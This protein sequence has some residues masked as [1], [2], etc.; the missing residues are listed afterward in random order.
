ML[1]LQS[2]LNAIESEALTLRTVYC[3]LYT[4]YSIPIESWIVKEMFLISQR[5]TECVCP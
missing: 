1:L 5:Y 4:E 2:L 3:I